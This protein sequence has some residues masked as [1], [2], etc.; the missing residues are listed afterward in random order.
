VAA[1][2][3]L[4]QLGQISLETLLE[5]LKK[6]E[7]LPDEFDIEAEITKLEAGDRASER[8]LNEE[9]PTD[10]P[11]GTDPGANQRAEQDSSQ[12]STA[13]DRDR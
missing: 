1:Y 4:Q 9:L 5:L 7:I 10:Q 13:G 8:V 3:G 11:N 12:G 2:S 6:G